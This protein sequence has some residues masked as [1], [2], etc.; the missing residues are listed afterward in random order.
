MWFDVVVR[1][2]TPAWIILWFA[3]NKRREAAKNCLSNWG[4]I[5]HY[6][7]N[8]WRNYKD[9]L[10]KTDQAR[11]GLAHK[12]FLTTTYLIIGLWLSFY[13]ALVIHFTSS[14]KHWLT[15][16]VIRYSLAQF[17][18][19][20]HLGKSAYIMNIKTKVMSTFSTLLLQNDFNNLERIKYYS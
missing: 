6:I 2:R 11:V 8:N 5:K 9:H 16:Y 3:D 18:S 12:L 4:C 14:K 17:H 7:I 13:T 10:Y 1:I 15:Q 20:F 19:F